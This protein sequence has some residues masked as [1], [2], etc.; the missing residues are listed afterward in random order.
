[1]PGQR[2]YKSFTKEAVRF[3]APLVEP[4]GFRHVRGPA[5]E[6][7]KGRW[8][9][10][11]GLQQ[12]QWDS[13]FCVNLGIAVPAFDEFWGDPERRGLIICW[14][15]NDAADPHGGDKWYHAR[16]KQYLHNSLKLVATTL[17]KAEPW[18]DQFQ[19]FSDVVE[20]Y[21]LSQGLPEAPDA[22]AHE[23]WVL[24]YGLVLLLDGA[25]E[26]A[27]QWLTL[28]KQLLDRPRYWHSKKRE[29]GYSE[30]PGWKLMK[31][32]ETDRKMKA[33]VESALARLGSS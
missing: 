27:L 7:D 6:R 16:Y 22:S 18:F 25:K 33:I 3:L 4:L 32:A 5:F 9:G 2:D 20:R 10:T 8:L 13:P 19:T 28:A 11:F 31:S 26:K 15:L 12:S 30:G 23:T 24:N 29:F 14:R 1:M 21:R 17:T